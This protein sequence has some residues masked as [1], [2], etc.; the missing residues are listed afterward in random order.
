M[1]RDSQYTVKTYAIW[2]RCFLIIKH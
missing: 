2:Q 1:D